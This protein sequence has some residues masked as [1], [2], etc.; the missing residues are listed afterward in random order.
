MG[1]IVLCA[2]VLFCSAG[3]AQTSSEI[4]YEL[5][6]VYLLNFLRFTE[7]PN[8]AFD[9]ESSPIV[10]GVVGIDPFGSILDETM[11]A[12]QVAGHPVVIKHF[13]SHDEISPCHVVFVSSSET[14]RL[15]SVLKKVKGSLTVSDIDGFAQLGGAIGFYVE[16]NKLRFEINLQALHETKAQVSS[17]LLR[18][19]KII[20]P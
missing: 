1:V 7:W 6:A 18:L 17:K 13:Q 10:L 20:N 4:E 3:N 15:R 16:N 19:A 8:S 11:H 9:N 5:K 14:E 12:E 2:S